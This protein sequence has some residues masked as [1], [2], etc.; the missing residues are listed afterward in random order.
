[1]RIIHQVNI[2]ITSF[3]KIHSKK[4]FKLNRDANTVTIYMRD[5][6]DMMNTILN[7]S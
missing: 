3:D 1:M 7:T 4:L 2:P 5:K 6:C